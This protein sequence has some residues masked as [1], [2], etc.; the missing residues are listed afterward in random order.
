M[1]SPDCGGKTD[2]DRHM[3]GR[4]RNHGMEPQPDHRGDLKDRSSGGK[5]VAEA[6]GYPRQGKEEHA[7]DANVVAHDEDDGFDDRFVIHLSNSP[8]ATTITAKSL[9]FGFMISRVS[10]S[11]SISRNVKNMITL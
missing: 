7:H 3:I 11:E 6:S 1:Q 4:V 10:S 8:A 5:G 9:A 2:Q